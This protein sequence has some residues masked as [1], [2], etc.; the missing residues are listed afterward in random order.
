[1]KIYYQSY[2]RQNSRSLR[3]NQTKEEQILWFHLRKKQIYNQQF[4]RQ[5]PIGNYIVDFVCPR[6]KLIIEVDGSDHEY[7]YEEDIK[8]Q[9][10]LE[11]LG[12]YIF[13]IKNK[14]IHYNLKGVMQAIELVVNSLKKG[15]NPSSFDD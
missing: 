15:E 8:R 7:K 4:Y 10:D 11:N 2:L 3:N 14:Q 9:K 1:M 12:F 6:I 13:R 5:K